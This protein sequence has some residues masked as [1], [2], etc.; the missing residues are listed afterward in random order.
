MLSIR[1]RKLGV[2]PIPHKIISRH[3]C[4]ANILVRLNTNVKI[5]AHPTLHRWRSKDK[6]VGRDLLIHPV[7][8]LTILCELLGWTRN[9]DALHVELGAGLIVVD[10]TI[11]VLISRLLLS[12]LDA[13]RL[14]GGPDSALEL[15]IELSAC[16]NAVV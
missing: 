5:V 3:H 10:N 15:T 4:L 13:R 2:L 16:D 11:A 7:Q 12:L 1:N 9:I 6:R 8:I 14:D